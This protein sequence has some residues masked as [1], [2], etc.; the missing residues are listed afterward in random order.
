MAQVLPGVYVSVKDEGLITVSP[1]AVNIIGIVGTA[2]WGPVNEGVLL[3]SWS[4]AVSAFKIDQTNLTL[5]KAL[6]LA[7]ANGATDV[8]AVRIDDG[9]ANK[10]SITLSAAITLNGIYKGTY[11]N[12]IAVSV[13]NNATNPS[14]RDVKITDGVSVEN[15]TNMPT[16]LA[17]VEAINNG[18][19]FVTATKLSDTLITAQ[20]S[21]YLTGGLDGHAVSTGAYALGLNVL[22]NLSVNFELCAGQS[23]AS[24]HASMDAH[25]Q[26]LAQDNKERIAIAGIA[27]GE[28]LATTLARTSALSSDRFVLV[29]PGVTYTSVLSGSEVTRSGAYAAAAIAG[30]LASLPVSY[31]LTNKIINKISALE[32]DYSDAELRQLVQARIVA[33]KKDNG[34]RVT[35][36]VTTSTNTA[37]TQITTRRIVDYVMGGTRLA[38]QD[39][40]GRLNNANIRSSLKN[41]ID[42]FLGMLVFEETLIAFES[43]V[44][45]T[46]QEEIQGIC[47]VNL[48]IQPVFSI[49]YIMATI[50]LE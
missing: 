9:T 48:R 37:W 4:D 17:I 46:R 5:L 13:T 2:A 30:K 50:Y 10:A 11:G 19:G 21:T 3:G 15:Y 36:G 38:G 32:Q 35:K 1:G 14:N 28:S 27:L 22:D 33:I 26:S 39:Y 45:A 40:I 8:Y 12:Q 47:R 23:D 34:F 25:V 20:S 42:A 29:A 49:D 44:S 31:S 24:L 6:E 41:V 16:N 18:S 43:E 7:F